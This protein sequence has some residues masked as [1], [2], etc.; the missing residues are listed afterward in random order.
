LLFC[1]YVDLLQGEK[2]FLESFHVKFPELGQSL[3]NSLSRFLRSS[4]PPVLPIYL[5]NFLALA[6]RKLNGKI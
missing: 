4:V 5:K 3:E 2:T 1:L 6:K